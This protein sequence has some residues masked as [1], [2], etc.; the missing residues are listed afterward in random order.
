[1][2]RRNNKV[3]KDMP[4]D[5]LKKEN[6]EITENKENKEKNRIKEIEELKPSD[7]HKKSGN[8]DDTTKSLRSNNKA[9]QD[10]IKLL[11]INTINTINAEKEKISAGNKINP[12]S[13]SL[14]KKIIENINEIPNEEIYK[15]EIGRNTNNFL[16]QK[17]KKSVEITKDNIFKSAR[18]KSKLGQNKNLRI[19][20]KENNIKKKILFSNRPV[21]TENQEKKEFH[22]PL[23]KKNHKYNSFIIKNNEMIKFLGNKN[24][25]TN[26]MKERNRKESHNNIINKNAKKTK[27]VNKI[28]D[29]KFN[30]DLKSIKSSKDIIKNNKELGKIKEIKKI[31]ANINIKSK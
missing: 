27:S 30:K 25:N 28:R 4:L 22:Q 19:E 24:K 9:N 6:K 21:K 18:W 8:F 23:D 3:K 26:N 11:N 14:S 15:N 5:N 20:E 13:D 2:R 29:F 12:F 10:K 16:S 1:M 7:N 17:R 31:N